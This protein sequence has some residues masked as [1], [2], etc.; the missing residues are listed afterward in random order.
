MKIKYHLIISSV[1]FFAWLSFYLL[2]SS[3][4]YFQEW[5][6]SE[7]IILSLLT[8]FAIAPFI[9]I[10]LMVLIP[11]KY[12]KTGIWLAFYASF[13]FAVYDYIIC[14]II[15]GEGLNIFISHWYLT[16][17]YF[18]VWIIGPFTGYI[19]NKFKQQVIKNNI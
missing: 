19:L 4:N 11:N 7:L 10:A 16:L 1:T 2:G 12:I 9:S 6:F 13:P 14:G 17:G 18:Y 15:K 5:N 8:I 3:S